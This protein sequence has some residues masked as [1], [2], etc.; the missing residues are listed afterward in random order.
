M[1]WTRPTLPEISGR[2]E[3]DLSSR[4]LGGQ[5][6]L[7]RSALAVLARAVAGAAHSLHGF[8]DWLSRQVL[9][10]TAEAEHLERW[11]RIWGLT[12]KAGAFAAGSV[13]MTGIDGSTV[14]AGTELQR[15]DGVLYET[16]A[17]AIIAAGTAT[18]QVEAVEPGASG[19][20]VAG[21]ALSFSSPVSGVQSSATVATGGI[22]GG[23]DEETDAELRA[24]LLARLRQPPAGGAAHDYEA[25]ALE[26]SGVTRAW[27]FGGLLGPGTVSVYVVNDN[28]S[29][30]TP[31]QAM[32]DAVS[33]YIEERRPVTAEVYVLAPVL[34][35][36]DMTINLSPNSVSVRASVTAELQALFA[37]TAEVGGTILLSHI[38]EAVSIAAGEVDHAVVSPS[39]NVVA[40]AGQIPVLG[41]LTFGD[42]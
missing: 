1:P 30:I 16:Q 40:G 20:A 23:A 3:S 19:D 26:V 37:R 13:T 21:V 38:R 12:R 22:A 35:A 7:R 28:A 27:V 33:A 36:V 5:A 42:L 6:L 18:A 4:L 25:W 41:V 24:R 10:D 32:L 31:P 8:Q 29:P 15:S 11:A 14:P 2:I 9:P 39:G 17:D 34:L